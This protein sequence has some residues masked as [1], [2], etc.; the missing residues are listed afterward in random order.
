M[1]PIYPNC[2]DQLTT[3]GIVADD[4]VGYITGTPSP[5][6]Q[7]YAS[8]RAAVPTLPGQIM[9]EQ[10]PNVPRRGEMYG[11]NQDMFQPQTPT[12]L[13]EQPNKKN[14][15]HTAKKVTAGVLIIGLTAFGLYKGKGLV[16]KIFKSSP[17]PASSNAPWYKRAGQW[18]GTKYNAAKTWVSGKFKTPAGQDPWYKKAGNWVKTKAIAVGD[19]FKNLFK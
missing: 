8:Q 19:W 12:P 1:N 17:K 13:P 11:P 15:W 16:D 3:H 2:F 14:G 6:L 7:N 18:I 9:P 10:L 4:V 5:Y